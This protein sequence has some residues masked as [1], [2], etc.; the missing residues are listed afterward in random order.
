MSWGEVGGTD[1]ASQPVSSREPTTVCLCTRNGGRYLRPLLDSL[2]QQT[3]PPSELLVGDDCSTDDTLQ[4]LREFSLSAP[5]PVEVVRNERRL[6]HV[7]NSEQLLEKAAGSVVLPCDQ[8][9]IW[10]PTKTEALT[11]AL[12]R[13]PLCG[14]AFCNSAFID[15]DDKALPGSLFETVGL[16]AALR[17]RLESGNALADIA[18]RNVVA[19]HALA[20]RRS[21]LPLVLPYGPTPYG[22]WW[23]ALVLAGTTGIA[24]VEECLVSYR[25]HGTNSVG[26]DKKLRFAERASASFSGGLLARADLLEA[27]IDRIDQV[28][29]GK[30]SSTDRLV[31]QAR[32]SHMRSRGTLPAKRSRR[33]AKVFH[34]AARGR[35]GQF[36]RGWKSVLMDL[37]REMPAADS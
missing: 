10:A 32:A 7:A 26:L 16:T 24:V 5:F 28:S 34:E 35:Y 18:N 25:L 2:A 20:I 15:A 13:L 31:L 14:A 36:G 3:S 27:T 19:G 17:A 33:V 8:D 29:P 30:L 9:D 1:Q 37:V 12:E 11:R 6:G 22:D 21:S 23:I 4:I